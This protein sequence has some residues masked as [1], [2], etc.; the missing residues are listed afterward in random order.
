M[1]ELRTARPATSTYNSNGAVLSSTW[2]S[3]TTG[4]VAP[5]SAS[6]VTCWAGGAV[7]TACCIAVVDVR[8][9]PTLTDEGL[10]AAIEARRVLAVLAYLG[11]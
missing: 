4:S 5:G 6:R 10:R 7:C 9:P 2:P 11:L 8:L 1:T 3:P